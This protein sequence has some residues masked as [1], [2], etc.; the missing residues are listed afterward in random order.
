MIFKKLTKDYLVYVQYFYC[1]LLRTIWYFV[2]QKMQLFGDAWCSKKGKNIAIEYN[3]MWM[4]V[5]VLLFSSKA[6]IKVIWKLPPFLADFRALCMVYMLL[7][8]WNPPIILIAMSWEN[9]IGQSKAL[10]TSLWLWRHLSTSNYF[11]WK[12]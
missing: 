9:Q 2:I 12:K 5:V 1:D 10:Y 4:Q 7:W 11:C 3:Y 8:W 6:E